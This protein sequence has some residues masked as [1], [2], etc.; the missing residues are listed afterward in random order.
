MDDQHEPDF[1]AW[2]EQQ[3]MEQLEQ[4]QPEPDPYEVEV[5]ERSIEL[6][7]RVAAPSA[8]DLL[9]MQALSWRV[10]AMVSQTMNDEL[11][12]SGGR[13]AISDCLGQSLDVLDTFLANQG[14][15]AVRR[16][17]S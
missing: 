9:A 2:K 7:E 11:T 14:I 10:R 1:D 8:T 6:E 15:K 5:Y 13:W 12:S 4:G 3:Y 17:D 16:D